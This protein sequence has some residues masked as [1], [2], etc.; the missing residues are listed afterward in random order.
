MDN[1]SE[2][3]IVGAEV[4]EVLRNI[5]KEEYYKVPR[6]ITAT[7]EK[8][9]DVEIKTKIDL[10]KSFQEQNISKR[11]KEIIYCI[12]LNYWLS[13]EEKHKILKK[14]KENE[15]KFNEKYSVEKLFEQKK[16]KEEVK[17]QSENKTTDLVKCEEKWYTK[18][19]KKIKKF[20]KRYN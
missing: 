15:E 19:L 2:F 12:S 9:K 3:E 17:I 11:A 20:F 16:K 6:K 5:P 13:E 7:F 10:T 4:Y 18:I 14:L 1:I 8:F